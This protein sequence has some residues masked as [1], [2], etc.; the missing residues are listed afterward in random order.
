MLEHGIPGDSDEALTGDLLEEFRSG[1]SEGWFWRQALAAWFVGW[2]KYLSRRR[3]LLIF[4][5]AWSTLAPALD[6][7]VD[8]IEHSRTMLN[9]AW[10]L[11]HLLSMFWLWVALNVAFIWTGMLLFVIFHERFA[12]SFSRAKLRRAF[13]LA[14]LI[15]LPMYFASF[16]L[17]NLFA[18]PG[19][20]IDQGALTPL[21]EIADWKIRADALRIP[22]FLTILWAMWA[23]TPLMSILSPTSVS[24]RPV[25]R[26][27]QA[28]ASAAIAASKTSLDNYTAKRFLVFVVGAGLL[29]A[30]IA[31]FLIC[32]LPPS[33]TPSIGSLATRA[34]IY[35]AAGALA[36]MA[37]IYLYWNS[38][39]S[40]FRTGPPLPFSLFA[41]ASGAG[42]IWVP[43]MV[44]FSEQLSAAT[45]LVGAIGA[46]LLTAALRHATSSVFAP[47]PRTASHSETEEGELFTES[48][49]RAPREMY[50]YVIAIC[51]YASGWAL[52]TRSNYTACTMLALSAS[53]FAWKRTFAP[54]G[55]LD[56]DREYKRAAL[57]L[58]LVFIPAVLVTTWSLIEG[59]GHRNRLEAIAAAQS[60]ESPGDD[61]ARKSQPDAHPS[62]PGI[63]GYESIVL[64]PLPEKKQ[65]IPPLPA[66]SNLLAP[67]TTQPLIIRFDGPYFYFQAGRRPDSASH[68]ARGTPLAVHIEATNSIPLSIEARQTLSTSIPVARCREMEVNIQ[69][70]DNQ[71][72][73]V[74]LAVL[75][76]DSTNQRKP[77]LYLGQQS[78]ESTLPMHF[79]F[80]SAPAFETLR[81]EVPAHSSLRRFDEI[82]VML[83]P[84][85]NH[86]LV[87][88]KI[89][90]RE[91]QLFPR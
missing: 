66:R 26:P 44:I 2:L 83:L 90:I 71:P 65:I 76:R 73:A 74:A 79:S 75:L 19:F 34:I 51:L 86:A 50:G 27:T 33:H 85:V 40:P 35:V 9:P 72:G 46:F 63:S 49:Y 32:R 70:R 60:R 64:W 87:G 78:I 36:G 88:P 56:T 80:K 41:L 54:G 38:P 7:L 14:P 8:R 42:W 23:A 59:V 45:A 4:A 43:S 77:G 61:A 29:N 5:L 12:S 81:F 84:D 48:L 22:Y 20:D 47:A 15:F 62:D 25:K 10:G 21:G 11:G 30:L 52:A 13:L 17:M 58:A 6:T 91:F 39:S 89:A 68:Q 28:G 31:G 69:N 3:S 37:G 16:V 82:T 1:R 18:Y 24:W 55:Q 57:R 67:G 53:L